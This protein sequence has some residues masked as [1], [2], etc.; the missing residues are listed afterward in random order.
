[1]TIH[2]KDSLGCARITE[3]LDLSLAVAASEALST[4]GLVTGEDSEILNLV[5]A[6]VTTIGTVAAD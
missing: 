3:V 5:T 4:E 1:M 6:G 2:T